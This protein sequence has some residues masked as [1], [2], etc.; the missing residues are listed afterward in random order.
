MKKVPKSEAEKRQKNR[1]QL[2]IKL[3]PERDGDILEKL[4]GEKKQTLVKK[5]IREYE[6]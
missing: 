2:N 5:L 6:K 3:D 1:V 4:K